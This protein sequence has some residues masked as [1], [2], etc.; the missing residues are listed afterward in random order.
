MSNLQK[1]DKIPSELHALYDI[2]VDT[3][4]D[5]EYESA[6]YYIKPSLK[7][8]ILNGRIVNIVINHPGKGYAVAPYLEIYGLGRNAKIKTIINSL[9]EITGCEVINSGEGYDY[10]TTTL[11][12]R[13]Y[14]ALVVSDQYSNN[15]WCI[16]SYDVTSSLWSKVKSQTYDVTKY[17][18][19]IDWYAPN[20]DKFSVINFSVDTYTDLNTISATIGQLVKVRYTSENRWI[21]LEKYAN[22]TSYDWAQSYKVVG[23]ENGTIQFSKLLYD[24]SNSP[25][26]YDGLLYDNIVYDNC[27]GIELRIILNSIKNDL[28]I[29]EL[30]TEYMNLFF[31][32]VRYAMSEQ[33][34]IDWIFK[35]SFVNVTHNVGSLRQLVTYKNDNLSNFEDY[36][37]EVKPYR[38]QVREYI[39]SYNNME[40]GYTAVTDFD[41][42]PHYDHVYRKLS[43]F[44][45]K[46]KGDSVIFDYDLSYKISDIVLTSPGTYYISE[47]NVIISSDSGSG[48]S[49]RATIANGQVTGIMLLSSGT[50]Y[51]TEPTVYLAGGQSRPGP[52]AKAVA[53]VTNTIEYPWKSWYDNLGFSVIDVQIVNPGSEYISEPVVS[54][55][56]ASGSGAVAKVFVSNGQVSRIKLLSEGKGYLT[57]PTVTI[58]GGQRSN[59]I[60]ATAVATIGKSVIRSNETVIK[61]DRITQTVLVTDL[62][63]TDTFTGT[64]SIIQFALSWAPDLRIGKTVV[65]INGIELIRDNYT[66]QVTTSNSGIHSGSITFNVA[67]A[68][69]SIVTVN[70]LKNV[71]LLNAVDRIEHYYNPQIGDIGKDF[72]QLMTGIDYGG[73]VVSG[74]TFGAS[75]G[76]GI[77]GYSSTKWD[78]TASIYNYKVTIPR[79]EYQIILPYT[80]EDGA[81]LNVY[82]DNG[83]GAQPIRIDDANFSLTDT[84]SNPNAIMATPIFDGVNNILEVPKWFTHE[85]DS[86]TFVIRDE[87]S[88]GSEET[89][90]YDVSLNGGTFE[91]LSASGYLAED[92]VI[93]GDKFDS[94]FPGPEEVVPGHVVDTIAIKVY[95]D[96]EGA[97]M[98]FKDMLNRLVFKRL[99]ANKQTS[100]LLPLKYN[101]LTIEL[102]DGSNFEIP[103]PSVNMPGVIFVNG[104]RIEYF[105]ITDNT[106]GQ[107][108]RGTLGTGIMLEY[109]AGTDVQEVGT[110]ETI[111]Y[112]ENTFIQ[113]SSLDN[114]SVVIKPD[115]DVLYGGCFVV[116]LPFLPKRKRVKWD[117]SDGIPSTYGQ[118]DE[119]EVFIGGYNYGSVWV[120]NAEYYINDIVTYGSYV[121]KCVEDHISTSFNADFNTNVTKS[122]WVFFIGNIRLQKAPYTVYNERFVSVTN[123]T[124]EKRF[125]ADF[126]VNGKYKEIRISNTFNLAQNT[127]ITVIKKTGERWS[128]TGAELAFIQAVDQ[129]VFPMN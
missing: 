87:R 64:G 75:T 98:Q 100:L 112:T 117:Y 127:V 97:Y 27:A 66:L 31:T 33:T 123:P 19:T 38:T 44:S 12:I 76:W 113:Q 51:L 92:L 35:T 125:P 2:T 95:T 10:S 46:T 34:Y 40:H 85:N 42:P 57:A 1:Y 68:A 16:Y 84:N 71:A 22:S 32:T 99:A 78:T 63:F 37:S 62:N 52:A 41:M 79:D 107:L 39:S 7:P 8:V 120:S 106:L 108:R 110:T 24:F 67:P 69:K 83:T 18:N 43:M 103:D 60:P 114:G 80:P 116:S 61:F 4:A 45:T 13:S 126:S 48:A 96:R 30:S 115:S 21:L 36:V 26:G 72:S 54:I 104:E 53:L 29:D 102:V 28:F 88:D 124:G 121:Y 109:P 93:D 94:A 58:S 15:Q 9:G 70:Y 101:D 6:N 25:I 82:Y 89:D 105:T 90:D 65:K 111:P 47:P 86:Y 77:A 3:Y 11:S 17:W 91:Y 5:L 118:C 14:C 50:G 59:G 55:D 49:A 56:S 74:L 23:S 20:Y 129:A 119:V 73:V 128:Y 122:K 81:R